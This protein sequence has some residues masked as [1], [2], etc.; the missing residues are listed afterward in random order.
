MT[1]L[2]GTII[3][4]KYRIDRVLGVGAMGAVYEGENER[5]HRRVAIKILHAEVSD[6]ADIVQRFEREAQAAGRIG[7]AHII[8]VLD[9]GSLASGQRFMV[10]EYLDGESLGA[11]IKKRE[12]MTPHEFTPTLHALLE[13]MASAH[14]A[15][16][17]H[18]DLKPDNIYLVTT[19]SQP[20][21]VKIL[22]FGISKFTA[23]E[24]DFGKTGA[25][26]LL[27]TPYYMS[28][29]QIRAEQIDARSDIYSI[30]VIV[31]YAIT[32]RLP[33]KAPTLN[34]LAIK[35]TTTQA[36]PPESVV[37]LDPQFAAII[38]KAMHSDREMRFQSAREFQ[39][40]VAH[41][42][43]TNSIAH[44]YQ[45]MN[46]L[47]PTSMPPG[48]LADASRTSEPNSAS[49]PNR[50]ARPT[51]STSSISGGIVIATQQGA[52]QLGTSHATPI[53]TLNSGLG[54]A[55]PG[56]PVMAPPNQGNGLMI[57]LGLVGTLFLAVCALLVYAFVFDKPTADAP[58]VTP[59]VVVAAPSPS[60]SPSPSPTPV[61]PTAMQAVPSALPTTSADAS[62]NVAVVAPSASALPAKT[63]PA[64]APTTSSAKAPTAS[65]AKAPTASI[66]SSS[67]APTPLPTS[68]GGVRKTA[69]G[70]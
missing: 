70:P 30:G 52:A 1:L 67:K 58:A 33:F 25:G 8:E 39:A 41:W 23:I 40:A 28:P 56:V 43:A 16:I 64:I 9:L 18:R 42:M 32:G 27:G 55:Q 36:D 60:P 17:I 12:R 66:G 11:R 63:L 54:L 26:M 47:P 51:P 4:G 7:S 49:W 6:H 65:S 44:S 24:T 35:I 14:D 15:H 19:K 57:T 48:L 29:E 45:R 20:D 21:F 68:S 3:D 37:A 50:D 34:E 5:I 22:D 53:G 10:M 2:P 31:Y 69:G 61:P 13:G 59:S 38:V 46:S 62:S